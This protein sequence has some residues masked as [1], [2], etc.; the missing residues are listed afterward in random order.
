[1]TR[2][3]VPQKQRK[4]LNVGRIICQDGRA[5]YDSW[6]F[7]VFG[8]VAQ[9]GQVAI[10]I[11]NKLIY[12]INITDKT[13]FIFVYFNCCCFLLPASFSVF[14]HFRWFSLS[15]YDLLLCFKVKLSSDL[16]IRGCTASKHVTL[17]LRKHIPFRYCG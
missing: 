9:V 1:M 15:R 3:R 2:L 6:N 10:N 16:I 17:S 12:A 13:T 4:S 14:L 5:S 7:F 11:C 8:S